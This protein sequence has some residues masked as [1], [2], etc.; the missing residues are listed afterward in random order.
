MKLHVIAGMPMLA[1]TALIPN[2]RSQRLCGLPGRF[3]HLM[4]FIVEPPAGAH[5]H[6]RGPAVVFAIHKPH[7]AAAFRPQTLSGP[8]ALQSAFMYLIV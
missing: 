1:L 4:P 2:T 3:P 8:R 6:T 7:N 5:L